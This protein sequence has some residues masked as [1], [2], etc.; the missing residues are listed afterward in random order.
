MMCHYGWVTGTGKHPKD[1][2]TEE[3]Q[4]SSNGDVAAPPPMLCH[5]PFP[6]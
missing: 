6:L 1:H 3:G 2:V 4:G 5:W